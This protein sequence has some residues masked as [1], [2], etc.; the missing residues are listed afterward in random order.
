[1]PNFHSPPEIPFFLSELRV[2]NQVFD[3]GGKFTPGSIR[4]QV[5]RAILFVDLL[6]AYRFLGVEKKKVCIIGAGPTGLTIA[7]RAAQIQHTEVWLV[8]RGER[9][10]SI[11]GDATHRLISPTL[12]DWPATHFQSLAYGPSPPYREEPADVVRDRWLTYFDEYLE[13]L[14]NESIPKDVRLHWLRQTK[15]EIQIVSGEPPWSVNFE[16]KTSL[17][18]QKWTEKF[19]VLVLARGFGKERGIRLTNNAVLPAYSFWEPDPYPAFNGPSLTESAHQTPQA[20]HCAIVVI[21]GGDGAIQDTLRFITGGLNARQI[22]QEIKSSLLTKFDENFLNLL[23]EI[24]N[25][26]RYLACSGFPFLSR[27]PGEELKLEQSVDKTILKLVSR[28][29]AELSKVIREL[30]Q[31]HSICMLFASPLLGPCYALN[32]F[33]A[34]VFQRYIQEFYRWDIL[35]PNHLVAGVECLHE[36]EDITEASNR[37]IKHFDQPHKVLYSRFDVREKITCQIIVPRL[38]LDEETV[39][40]ERRS[41]ALQQAI[42]Y[43]L[44]DWKPE[45]F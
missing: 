15:A 23:G 14:K 2:N 44:P 28:A 45:E 18:P 17:Q 37:A 12:Y 31:S 40:C 27:E 5:I 26:N 39:V 21:G 41:A 11:L 29:W 19:D 30:V 20:N 1:M 13:S 7:T 35:R 25:M 36:I 4:D 32:R 34:Y 8:D 10:L 33:L 6:Y 3:L 43:W 38:G 22:L 42:P 24:D 9:P 16:K